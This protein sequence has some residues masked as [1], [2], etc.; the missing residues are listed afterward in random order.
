MNVP[1][2][3]RTAR[4]EAGLTQAEL[5]ARAAISQP[6]VAA[7]EAGQVAPAVSTFERLLRAAGRRPVLHLEQ[8]VPTDLSG[9]I[10][11]LVRS[12]RQAIRKVLGEHQA[13]RV[14]VFGSVARGQD[15]PD[16]DLD[17]LIELPRPTFMRLAALRRRLTEVLGVP[18]DVAIPGMLR[19][20]VERAALEEAVPL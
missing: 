4:L 17:L 10:G 6:N 16:S 5:A 7:Y 9:P 19:P 1:Q 15:R 8:A 11:G 20:E 14:L 2:V 18:V 3:I 12:H 13:R